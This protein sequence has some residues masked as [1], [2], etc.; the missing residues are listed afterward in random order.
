MCIFSFKYGEVD[1]GL[2]TFGERNKKMFH[3]LS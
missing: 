1:I 2:H 3:H